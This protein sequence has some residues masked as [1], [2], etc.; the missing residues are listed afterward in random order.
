MQ[1]FAPFAG[2]PCL[3]VG[4]G[5]ASEKGSEKGSEIP[6]A[7]GSPGHEA[8]IVRVGLRSLAT[9]LVKAGV[10]TS[11]VVAMAPSRQGSTSRVRA[12]HRL[13]E[14]K[15][16]TSILIPTSIS[17]PD[18]FRTRLSRPSTSDSSR[19]R[20]VPPAVAVLAE[21]EA[22]S[23]RAVARPPLLLLA[24]RRARDRANLIPCRPRSG[25]LVPMRSTARAVAAGVVVVVVV[26]AEAAAVVV[27][28]VAVVV[29]DTAVAAVDAVVGNA[30]LEL[31]GSGA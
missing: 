6:L 9:K 25:S 12:L 5:M 2:W 11:V 28:A 18:P 27:E 4:R 17:T 22:A 31:N 30:Q 14:S 23:V 16:G 13:P 19:I 1:T 3:N 7:T 10:R 24:E 20:A 15:I 8:M 29:V 26:V 21:E